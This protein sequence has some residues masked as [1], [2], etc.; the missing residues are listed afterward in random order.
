LENIFPLN[1]SLLQVLS[2]T[3]VFLFFYASLWSVVAIIKKRADTA[4]IAWGM[5]FIFVAWISMALS[6]VTSYGLIVNS[7]VTLWGL[8]LTIH[9]YMRNKTR[10]EDFR[11]RELKNKWGN[12]LN[13]RIFL[14]VFLLQAA[15]LFVVALPVIW[16]HTHPSPSYLNVPF[17]TALWLTGFILEAVADYQLLAFKKNPANTGKLL[18]TG[19]WSYVRH[20]N[21]LGEIIQW[22][23]IWALSLSLPLT[24]M[25]VISPLLITFLIVKVSGVAPLEKKMKS[26]PTFKKYA[27]ETPSLIP[28][29]LV[30]GTLYTISWVIL[31][32]Y[33][34]R[35]SF[36]IPLAALILC[37]A[38]QFFLFAKF[39]RKSLLIAAPL[40]LYAFVLGTL[41]ETSFIHMPIL[42][43]PGEWFLPPLWLLS[44]YPLFSL[45]LNSSFLF[46]NKHLALPFFLGGAGSLISYISGERLGGVHLYP[47]YFYPIAAL[48]WGLLL[49]LLIIINRRLIL[50]CERYTKEIELP[51][52]VFF[53]GSCPVCSREMEKLQ[54]RKQ[55]GN[56]IYACP[57]SEEDLQKKDLPFTYGEAMQ[58]I[59]AVD[60][61]GKIYKGTQALSALYARTD[62]P[63]LAILLQA[64]L[65]R[66]FFNICYS[67][68][69]FFRPRMHNQIV[70]K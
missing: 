1:L 11:Y 28:F 44:L 54:Q 61:E 34:A 55:T 15:I 63:F 32:Y 60:G 30:N 56:V 14:Q 38:A 27:L 64:P 2:Y 16:I 67:I 6:R 19:A 40:S 37:Y 20:P 18:T 31:V 66:S 4:D 23:A 9:I 13:L 42:Y 10:G 36:W 17:F 45:T 62:L 51:L 39:D 12:H 33:G 65:F 22:W 43:Y 69:A 57:R 8:R 46:L 35:G 41:Q 24:W 68:W 70:K 21:Y 47:P 3:G 48:S 50:L 29:S 7:L 5:G 59:H 25:L 49:T 26:D 58:A 52:T 53:D